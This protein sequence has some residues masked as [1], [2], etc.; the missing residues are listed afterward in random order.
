MDSLGYR[1][2]DGSDM[3]RR[4]LGVSLSR[5][6]KSEKLKSRDSAPRATCSRVARSADACDRMGVGMPEPKRRE[7][8]RIWRPGWRIGPGSARD[9]RNSGCW[10][11]GAAEFQVFSFSESRHSDFQIRCLLCALSSLQPPVD[12]TRA[13]A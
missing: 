6:Q 9:Q 7:K 11:G 2:G 5:P 10:R 8:L 1:L 12:C 3:T 4:V 13:G